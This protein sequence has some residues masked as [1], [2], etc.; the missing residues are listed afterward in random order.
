MS[1]T[2]SWHDGVRAGRASK[3]RVA[4][5]TSYTSITC[6]RRISARTSTFSSA[7]AARTY[8]A[9]RTN[10]R[11]DSGHVVRSAERHV[12][13][14]DVLRVVEQAHRDRSRILPRLVGNRLPAVVVLLQREG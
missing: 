2:R 12:E 4:A 10:S 3:Y 14:A 8:R 6:S 13:R 11:R 1:A 9:T 7:A 5:G